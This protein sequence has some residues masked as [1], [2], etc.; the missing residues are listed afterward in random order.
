MSV[1]L[2]NNLKHQFVGISLGSQSSADTGVAI[3]DKNLKIITLDKLYTIQ[4][5]TFFFDNFSSKKNAIFMISIAD[6][7]TMLNCK[8]KVLA[9][10]FQN[11]N[12]NVDFPNRHDWMNRLTS[13]GAELF[14]EY[15]NKGADIFRYD[16]A[17]LKK[18]L[19]LYGIYKTRTPAECKYL[20]SALRVK[21]KM[22]D[23]MPNMLPASQLEAILGAILARQ[24]YLGKENIDYNEIYS[25][26]E[27]PVLNL[28]LDPFS[29][30]FT[31]AL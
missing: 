27:L 25:F 22:D 12:N 6:D 26:K 23:I 29:S 9:K 10:K 24:I 4:D 17:E 2:N 20:Q 5:L 28:M 7:S 11:L 18:I 21:F 31:E 15:K 3:L 1:V 16:I 19:G 8:W 30:S 14:K 13:R